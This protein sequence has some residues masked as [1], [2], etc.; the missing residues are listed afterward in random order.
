[1]LTP[2]N[3][4]SEDVRVFAIVVAELKLR[5]VQRQILAADLVER[6]DHTALEDRPEALNCVGVDC[7]DDVLP[8]AVIDNAMRESGAKALIDVIGVGTDQADL[9]GNCF[10]NKSLDFY[11]I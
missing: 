1:M 6:T 3:C 10:P 5:D 9:V 11:L 8:D 4:R 2:L 7:T